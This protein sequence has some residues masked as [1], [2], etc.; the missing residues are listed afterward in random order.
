MGNDEQKYSRMFQQFPMARLLL[1]VKEDGTYVYIDANPAAEEY[2]DIS[3]EDMFGRESAELFNDTLVEHLEQSYQV[4]VNSGQ[5]VSIN[6]TPHFLGGVKVQSF[7]LNPVKNA[8]GEVEFIDV[9]ARPDATDSGHVQR[10]RDDAI[11]LLTSLF[12]ATGVGIMVTDHHGKIVRINDTFLHDYEWSSGELIGSEFSLVIPPEDRKLAMKLHDAFIERG[13]QGSR[14]MR[15]LKKDGSIADVWLTT[16]LLELSHR[17]RFMVA[18]VR[19]ITERK[20]MIRNLRKAKENSDTANKAKSSFL[21]NMSHELR[22]PLNAIIGFSEVIKSETFGAI[23]NPKYAE[24][25]EDIHFS[26]RHL[27]DIINDVLDMSKIEAGKVELVESEVQIEEVFHSVQV[28]M[29]D[30]VEAAKVDLIFRFEDDVPHLRADQRFLRQILINLVSN[31]VKFSAEGEEIIVSAG[32]GKDQR[33][34]LSVE[35][36]GCGIP[37]DKIET[38]LEPFGQV[39]DASRHNHGQGTGLGLPLAKAMMELH[40]GQLTIKSGVGQGTRVILDFPIER[41]M[42][43]A[44]QMIMDGI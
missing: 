31:A 28:I 29:G 44:T 24:Y 1:S 13:R 16:V 20:N 33:L 5:T 15:I 42:E 41:T 11:L 22:T 27:L 14:E 10:E 26:A 8:E 23:Q 38:V 3:K 21:A 43:D 7:T 25:M 18:T 2:F 40:G 35:D 19:N 37:D 34:H 4:C 36:H 6:I 9:I 32:L 39:T 17:R 30:R 12:D